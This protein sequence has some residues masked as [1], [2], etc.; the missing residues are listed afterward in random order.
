MSSVF[1]CTFDCSLYACT[2]SNSPYCL[3]YTVKQSYPSPTQ[4]WPLRESVV[5][6]YFL[7]IL[8]S[9]S[10]TLRSNAVHIHVGGYDCKTVDCVQSR[11]VYSQDVHSLHLCIII[12]QR[13]W[14]T[15]RCLGEIHRRRTKKKG[16]TILSSCPRV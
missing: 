1:F 8:L 13:I 16:R 4:K 7:Y 14:S 11:P 10:F 2:Q 12:I 15:T 3:Q 5:S 9:L 6:I